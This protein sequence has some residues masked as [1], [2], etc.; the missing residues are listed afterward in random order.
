MKKVVE[1]IEFKENFPVDGEA[2]TVGK[3][4]DGRFFFAWG[5]EYPYS[6]EIPG[7]EIPDGEGGI[8]Y[9]PTKEEAMKAFSEA[10]EAA[11]E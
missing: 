9:H 11:T 6:E 10:V 1:I 3:V 5:S 2:Y 4:E 8:S 7:V